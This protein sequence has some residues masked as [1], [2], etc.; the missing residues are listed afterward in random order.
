MKKN[1]ESSCSFDSLVRIPCCLLDP[2]SPRPFPAIR[3]GRMQVSEQGPL[4]CQL[5]R[6]GA[7]YLFTAYYQI[8]SPG[9]LQ[10]QRHLAELHWYPTTLGSS[11]A[12]IDHRFSNVAHV[13]REMEIYMLC[14]CINN[15]PGNHR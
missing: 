5:G 2:S 13:L 8:L 10:D 12:S 7:I 3:P 9:T 15:T 4:Q 11:R 6:S 14:K 1:L